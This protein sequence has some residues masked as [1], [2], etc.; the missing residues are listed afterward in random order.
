MG[1]ERRV[2]IYSGRVLVRQEVSRLWET[3]AGG[4][5]VL[6]STKGEECEELRVEGIGR[7]EG[8][9]AVRVC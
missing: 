9:M 3:A 4:I 2:S 6:L 1:E 5:V 7:L 8:R